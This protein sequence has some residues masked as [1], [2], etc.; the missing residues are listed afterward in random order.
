M[1][2][3]LTV[4]QIVTLHIG[5]MRELNTLLKRLT[6]SRVAGELT[7]ADAAAEAAED[8][9]LR[10]KQFESNYRPPRPSRY[11]RR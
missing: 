1:I 6:E 3:K 5:M 11:T 4:D 10:I 2:K 9:R 8:M 7:D